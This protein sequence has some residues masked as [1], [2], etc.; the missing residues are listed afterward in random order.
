MSDQSGKPANEQPGPAF[1]HVCREFRI[2]GLDVF[3]SN[4]TFVFDSDAQL[5]HFL[6][7]IPQHYIA[8]VQHITL[9]ST[10]VFSFCVPREQDLTRRASG[11]V[12]YATLASFS[13]LRNIHL[14]ISLVCDESVSVGSWFL[15]RFLGL[16][17]LPGVLAIE[18]WPE[19]MPWPTHTV[20]HHEHVGAVGRDKVEVGVCVG[21]SER[22][23]RA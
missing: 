11:V 20:E 13:K 17:D 9:S 21:L 7:T 18:T 16:Q 15:A 2:V 8:R 6:T 1:L 14:Y 23:G 19:S 3:Y 12:N 22:V 4:N 10:I 5:H